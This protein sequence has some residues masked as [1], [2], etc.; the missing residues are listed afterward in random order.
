MM[1]RAWRTWTSWT[2]TCLPDSSKRR[3]GFLCVSSHSRLSFVIRWTDLASFLYSEERSL[4][5][6]CTVINAGFLHYLI[7]ELL[8]SDVV[9]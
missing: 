9:F 8:S 3:I 6:L 5:L 7:L 4:G 2:G 1:P